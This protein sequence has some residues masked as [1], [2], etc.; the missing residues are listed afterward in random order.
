MKK[1]LIIGIIFVTISSTSFILLKYVAQIDKQTSGYNVDN[2]EFIYTK[3]EEKALKQK[4]YDSIDDIIVDAFH[5]NPVALWMLGMSM[6]TGSAGFP[7]DTVSANE[8]F[9]QSASLGFAPSINQVHFMYLIDLENPFLA[10]TYLNLTVSSGHIELLGYYNKL[11]AEF[12]KTYGLNTMNE[13]EKIAIHKKTLISKY[14]KKAQEEPSNF[15]NLNIG[16]GII[17]EDVLFDMEFW[18]G[19]HNGKIITGNLEDWLL[20]PVNYCLMLDRVADLLD[21]KLKRSKERLASYKKQSKK[22]KQKE[23]TRIS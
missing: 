7:L 12:I 13:V 10:L 18:K 20:E 6:L 2:N 8:Y 23:Y 14:C 16:S 3:D 21:E 11:R 4:K 5:G 9:V 15:T 1:L 22:S 19:I 17:E